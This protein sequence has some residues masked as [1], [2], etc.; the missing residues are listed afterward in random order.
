MLGPMARRK[1]KDPRAIL[2]ELNAW[3]AE[4]EIEARVVFTRPVS[5]TA[6]AGAERSLGRR[7]PPA[8]VEFVTRNGT[9]TISGSLT[10]RGEGNDTVLLDPEGAARAT[11]EYRK[12]LAKSRDTTSQAIL[13]DGLLFC[14]D[15]R[16]EFFHLFVL[17]SANAQG[18]MKTRSYDYQDPGNNDGHRPG[19]GPGAGSFASVIA[20][21]AAV[22][23]ARARDGQGD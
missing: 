21:I 8:Y 6:I 10:G 14:A 19:G 1:A 2:D 5:R 16:G 11:A 4:H 3:L 7:F 18:E 22:V 20:D 15:P 13:A 12:R 23:R 17:S 9:F